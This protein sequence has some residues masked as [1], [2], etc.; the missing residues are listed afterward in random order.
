MFQ[1]FDHQKNAA[2]ANKS[3]KNQLGLD[4][5]SQINEGDED[6]VGLDCDLTL[7]SG[8]YG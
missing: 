5:F 2:K 1:T 4:P 7:I 6:D 3:S 8:L